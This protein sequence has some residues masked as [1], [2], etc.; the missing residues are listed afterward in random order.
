ML[1]EV[2]YLVRPVD[3]RSDL[4]R[5]HHYKLCITCGS[6]LRDDQPNYRMYLLDQKGI[7]W[8]VLREILYSDNMVEF[9]NFIFDH[10]NSAPLVAG[11][12]RPVASI[13]LYSPV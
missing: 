9:K 4:S 2:S 11:I 8:S 5:R 7:Y 10:E 12:V 6:E 3:M 13:A 1:R